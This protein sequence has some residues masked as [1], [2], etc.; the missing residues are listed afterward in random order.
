[1]TEKPVNVFDLVDPEKKKPSY[2]WVL[3]IAGVFLIGMFFFTI[4][5]VLHTDGSSTTTTPSK[6]ADEANTTSKIAGYDDY[7]NYAE[8]FYIAAFNLSYTNY[9]QQ[10]DNAS[11]LMAPDL[12]DYY[13]SDFLDTQFRQKILLRKMYIT[14][15]RAEHSQVDTVSG[16]Q[17]VVRV[18]GD[19]YFNSDIDGSQIQLHLS[20]LIT[21]VKKGDSFQV[22]NFVAR[23]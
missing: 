7:I 14:F 17:V 2:G 5:K 13:K 6:A 8:R 19:N 3:P 9:S 18:S 21:V 11:K 20:M 1:M 15:Q 10:I 22:I 23:L 4:Y 12:A 16:D